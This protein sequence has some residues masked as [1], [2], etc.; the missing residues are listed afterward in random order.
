MN[1]KTM[2]VD[3]RLGTLDAL[4]AADKARLVDTARD[5]WRQRL[6]RSRSSLHRPRRWVSGKK[7][8]KRAGRRSEKAWLAKRRKLLR[9]ELKV[10]LRKPA[11]VISAAKDA[12]GDAWSQKHEEARK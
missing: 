2:A 1:D 5:I 9:K 8:I 3:V 7:K 4:S 12:S 11:D 10:G 6:P